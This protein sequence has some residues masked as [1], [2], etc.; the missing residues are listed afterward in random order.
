MEKPMMMSREFRLALQKELNL[1]ADVIV[2]WRQDENIF[3]LEEYQSY[4]KD[5]SAL[6][7]WLIE[8]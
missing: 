5:L 3:D 7:K 6:L 8:E 4:H 2:E 1:V